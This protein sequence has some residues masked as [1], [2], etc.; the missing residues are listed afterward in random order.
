MYFAAANKPL[1][2]TLQ[3]IPDGKE[4]TIATLKI[5]KE[6]VKAGKKSLPVRSLAVSLTNGTASKDWF[7]ELKKLHAFVRDRIRYVRDIR[8][9]ETVQTPDATLA[10]GAG[11]CD[12]K[13]VL[14]ASLLESIG[15]PTRFVAIGFKPDDFAHVYV[16]SRVGTSWVPLETTEP[17][18]I[19]WS[20]SGVVSRLTIFN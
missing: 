5:M 18:E 17:V 8:D 13:S 9:V 10:I 14:L 7:G 11:D 16:E 19:G 2:A 6:L 15:H 3:A 20:P 1:S 4:G 12:D